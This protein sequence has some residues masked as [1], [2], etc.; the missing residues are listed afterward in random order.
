MKIFLQDFI[1]NICFKILLEL[2]YRGI[3]RCTNNICFNYKIRK[4]IPELS[5]WPILPISSYTHLNISSPSA[6]SDFS[7]NSYCGG[8][9]GN[10]RHHKFSCICFVILPCLMSL[11]GP[12]PKYLGSICSAVLWADLFLIVSDLHSLRMSCI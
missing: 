10:G 4:N 8:T 12:N 11:T 7:P 2:H 1:K 9:V 5:Q 3:I 6:A